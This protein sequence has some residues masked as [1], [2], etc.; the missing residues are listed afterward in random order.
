MKTIKFISNKEVRQ[1]VDVLMVNFFKPLN[2][3]FNK[4]MFTELLSTDSKDFITRRDAT[5]IM[6]KY[7][8]T[9]LPFVLILDDE[10]P[11]DKQEYAAVYSE[12]DPITVDRI[13]NKI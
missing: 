7:A 9:K 6:H 1:E 12:E 11:E 13:N 3:G 5:T 8:V 4:N 2:K 10:L